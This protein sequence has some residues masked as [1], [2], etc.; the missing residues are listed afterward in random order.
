VTALCSILTGDAASG[1]GS[2]SRKDSVTTTKKEK[3]KKKMIESKAKS[4]RKIRL[5][6][7]ETVDLDIIRISTKM[8]KINNQVV[9][10]EG[11]SVTWSE[12]DDPKLLDDALDA[13]MD[14][15]IKSE[16]RKIALLRAIERLEHKTESKIKASSSMVN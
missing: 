12:V 3:R 6:T 14:F 4:V 7:G 9:K 11:L 2:R 15:I 10:A 13:F 8:T 5:E 1:I 16:N